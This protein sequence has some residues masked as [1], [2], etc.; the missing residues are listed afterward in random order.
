ME[1]TKIASY[2]EITPEQIAEWKER[3]GPVFKLECEDKACIVKLA[4]RKTLSF[5][6]SSGTKDPMKFNE[7][8][9]RGCWL[10][11]DMEILENDTYFISVSQKI[12]E[13]VQFKTATLE[14]L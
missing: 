13:L 2:S 7:M 3:H 11:G 10:G 6:S 5:A 4:D 9:L 14:K 1:K 12:A 8:I